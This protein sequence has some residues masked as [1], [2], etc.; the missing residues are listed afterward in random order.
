MIARPKRLERLRQRQRDTAHAVAVRAAAGAAAADAAVADARDAWLTTATAMP[1]VG[2][3]EHATAAIDAASNHA[4]ACDKVVVAERARALT[5]ARAWQRADV[6][7]AK[8]RV[9]HHAV[10]TAIEAREHDE[11]AARKKR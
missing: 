7:L 6:A 3:L 5:A 4:R 11:L 1:T 8:A 2:E 10:V 9:V